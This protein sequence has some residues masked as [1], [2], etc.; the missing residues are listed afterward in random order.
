MTDYRE[1]VDALR[2]GAEQ[3]PGMAETLG[4]YSALLDIQEAAAI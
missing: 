3:R 2:S 4:L 1:I